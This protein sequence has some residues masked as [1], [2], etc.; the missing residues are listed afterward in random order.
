MDEI[1]VRGAVRDARKGI[2]Q[3]QWLMRSLHKV[4]VRTSAEFQK[5]YNS[6]YKVRQRSADWYS[7]YYG[8]LEACK[9]TGADFAEI[10]DT[11]WDEL[12]RYEPSF[13][14][15]LVATIDPTKP[16][17]D[18]FVLKNIGLRAP[19]YTSAGKK[20]E[21]KTVYGQI[22]DWYSIRLACADGRRIVEI[23]GEEVPEDDEITDLKKLDFVLWQT[24]A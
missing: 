16:V 7:T 9:D 4:D 17:W 10:L 18:Q 5:R 11:L 6:F 3:Y 1:A 14:S 21:A 8:L 19:S 2:A 23:F 20:E 15:K 12:G 13:S 22:C 24:R